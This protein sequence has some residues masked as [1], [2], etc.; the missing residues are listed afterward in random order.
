M[1][2][3][4]VDN[5]R[6]PPSDRAAGKAGGRVDD[7]SPP[8]H[9]GRSA[10]GRDVEPSYLAGWTPPSISEAAAARGRSSRS[11][12]CPAAQVF[13]PAFVSR[14]PDRSEVALKLAI[15]C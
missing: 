6:L 7:F 2:P 11:A 3:Q 4:T 9:F 8:P 5:A 14:N 10:G 12:Y 13:Y 15:T 1:P